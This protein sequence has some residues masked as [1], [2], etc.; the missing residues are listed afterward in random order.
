MLITLHDNDDDDDPVSRLSTLLLLLMMMMMMMMMLI[1][2][3]MTCFVADFSR[4]PPSAAATRPPVSNAHTKVWYWSSDG[5]STMTVMY[6]AWLRTTLACSSWLVCNDSDSRR[7]N[8]S[9]ID[10]S[11]SSSSSTVMYTAYNRELW[12]NGSTIYNAR[13]SHQCHNISLDLLTSL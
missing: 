8:I 1:T 2:I 12:C 10:S 7:G 6:T 5:V 3:M 9:F 4:R 13:V 11:S